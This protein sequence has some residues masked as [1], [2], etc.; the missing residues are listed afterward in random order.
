MP[1]NNSEKNANMAYKHA[2]EI[3]EFAQEELQA[4]AI[5]QGRI[6]DEVMNG[7]ADI[8]ERY[9]EEYKAYVENREEIHEKYKDDINNAQQQGAKGVEELQRLLNKQMEEINAVHLILYEEGKKIIEE[10]LT[11]YPELDERYH[12]NK[13]KIA[14]YEKIIKDVENFFDEVYK[15]SKVFLPN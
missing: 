2:K 12:N 15:L 8:R 9:E 11:H 5:E 7:N 3:Y 6:Y 14:E 1:D 4:A 13:E 10:G